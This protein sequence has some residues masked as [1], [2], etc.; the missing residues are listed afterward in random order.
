MDA[1]Y[2]LFLDYD[3]HGWPELSP[4]ELYTLVRMDAV[5]FLRFPSMGDTMV[6]MGTMHGYHLKAPKARLTLEEQRL[7]TI[8]SYGADSGYKYWSIRHGRNTLRI[9]EKPVVKQVGDRFVGHRVEAGKPQLLEIIKKSK[10]PKG[11]G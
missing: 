2:M 7:A 11:K 9:S 4:E 8:L 5:R 1:R 3:Q 6:I 10:N